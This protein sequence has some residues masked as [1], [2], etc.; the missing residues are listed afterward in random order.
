MPV[1]LVYSRLQQAYNLQ[2]ENRFKEAEIEASK[3]LKF[4]P[5]NSKIAKFRRFNADIER[6]HVGMI[7]SQN[8]SD[9]IQ[10]FRDERAK[11]MTLVR[12][13]KAYFE[14]RQFDEAERALTEAIK[15]DPRNDIAYYYLRLILEAK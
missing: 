13:G 12:D 15:L 1:G 7:P 14:L 3:A 8:L 9:Q 11:I 10:S 5:D 6:A 2:D 4:D